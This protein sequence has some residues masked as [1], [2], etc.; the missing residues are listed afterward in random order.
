MTNLDLVAPVELTDA[1]LDAVAA[2]AAAG[3]VA[4]DVSNNHVLNNFL[5]SNSVLNG[6]LNNNKVQVPVGIAVAV[7][8]QAAAFAL[9]RA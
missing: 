1:E 5:N 6:S 4:I 2:G 9:P 8:G 7:L 3:L